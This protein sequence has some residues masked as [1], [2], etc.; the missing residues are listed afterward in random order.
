[1]V[2]LL[3]DELAMTAVVSPPPSCNVYTPTELAAAMVRALGDAPDAR[4]L[5]PCVGRGAF[6]DVLAQE[7]VD[8]RRIVGLDLCRA[9]EPTDA[10]AVVRRGI[11][12]LRW[13]LS[14]DERFDRVVAN[15]PYVALSK[16]PLP[17]QNAAL[18]VRTSDGA[19][20]SRGGNCWNAFL[21]A[22]LRLLNNGASIAF[23]LPAAFDY[24]N[25][26]QSLRAALPNLFAR[27]EVHRCR[28]PIF[29]AVEEGSIVLVARG[30]RKPNSVTFRREYA[31]LDDLVRGLRQPSAPTHAMS[32][33]DGQAVKGNGVRLG[34]IMSIGL[35]A[36]TG[37]ASYF[38]MTDEE[39]RRHSLTK[40]AVVPVVSR[41]KHIRRSGVAP[42]HCEEL[43]SGGERIWL[44]RPCSTDL[45]QP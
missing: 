36:V 8:A 15:P 21:C 42:E 31:T 17:I 16:V 30:F 45:S 6:L 11:E 1:M 7:R 38:L 44:F 4:W 18:A 37:D 22:S 32:R 29:A 12:F 19:P 28:T 26:A 5:E 23:V 39:R 41:S 25:Y 40:T 43:L 13:S 9:T 2:C 20:I 24:A 27:V 35:G 34:D 10:Y 3:K 14:T 33:S